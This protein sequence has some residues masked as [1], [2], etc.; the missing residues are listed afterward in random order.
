MPLD[1]RDNLI[2]N[3]LIADDHDSLEMFLLGQ[4]ACFERDIRASGSRV[5]DAWRWIYSADGSLD[6][7]PV[8]CVG[9]V[10][11][12]HDAHDTALGAHAR[13]GGRGEEREH[14][15]DACT[16]GDEQEG[17]KDGGK[18]EEIGGWGVSDPDVLGRGGDDAFRPVASCGDDDVGGEGVGAGDG[19]EGVPFDDG[20]EAEAAG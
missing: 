6:E 17:V 15:A 14:G 5:E 20:G 11:A 4:I 2:R 13:N 19:G 9:V 1:L 8:W 16:R 10:H 12:P 3:L 18:G 7:F